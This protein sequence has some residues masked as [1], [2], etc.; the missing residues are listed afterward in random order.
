MTF[1]L[2]SYVCQRIFR[3]WSLNT[4]QLQRAIGELL[5]SFRVWITWITHRRVPVTLCYQGDV[6]VH[7]QSGIS[8]LLLYLNS[9]AFQCINWG[10]RI[11]TCNCTQHSNSKRP[12][13]KAVLHK[14]AN[15]RSL[16]SELFQVGFEI[17]R[18]PSCCTWLLTEVW[19]GCELK[20]PLYWKRRVRWLPSVQE[21]ESCLQTC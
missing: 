2:C 10:S 3:K 5:S 9:C 6:K 8:K 14:T 20:P 16:F 1:F 15:K 17:S 18:L 13:H 21:G 19:S 11:F 4:R 12:W 7:L